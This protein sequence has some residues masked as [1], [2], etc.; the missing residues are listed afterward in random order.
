MGGDTKKP[1]ILLGDKPVLTCVLDVFEKSNYADEI[2]VVVSA[3]DIEK[4][5]AE[6]IEPYNFRKI[7]DVLAGGETRQ[8]SVFNGLQRI[9]EDA[10]LVVVHDGARP[11]VTEDI[12]KSCCKAAWK[13]SSAI[14]AV[15]VKN[16]IKVADEENFVL[17]TPKRDE[18]WAIQTPQVFQRKLLLKAHL[19]ARDKQIEATDDA[20]LVEQLGCKVKLVMGSY[21][22]IKITTQED[23]IIAEAIQKHSL[24]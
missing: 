21:R 2:F 8:E 23:L 10:D 9:S 24:D 22:N 18:L 11:F 19:R 7:T 1:Y 5:V 12:I 16:T 15:P 14:A 13:W 20:A 4:C 6:V 3:E 17:N